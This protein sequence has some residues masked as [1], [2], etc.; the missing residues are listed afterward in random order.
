V[1]TKNGEAY[2][3]AYGNH[4]TVRDVAT[5]KDLLDVEL[6]SMVNQIAFLEGEDGIFVGAACNDGSLPVLSVGAVDDDEST[7]RA[8][9]AIE[10]V[11]GVVAGEERF[12]C[13]QSINYGYHVITANSAGVVSVMNLQGAITMMMS[14]D[15][16]PS[17]N[18]GDANGLDARPNSDDSDDE[19][20]EMELAV[21]I[22]ASVQLGSGARVTCL[23][24]WASP[25][26][27]EEE[28][29]EEDVTDT[30]EPLEQDEGDTRGLKRKEPATTEVEM[31]S[32]A[33]EKARALVNQ[34]KK[35]E[36]KRAKKKRIKAD[37]D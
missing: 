14:E 3:W 29:E 23:A 11:E 17:E 1:W 22:I 9:M 4:I 13:I 26:E 7:R 28:I 37:A 5:G 2:G 35:L 8:L 32:V 20:E 25:L 6:P 24:A 30:E 27:L 33:V 18:D 12:K 15:S 36:K 19:R 16:D 21:D 34:A 31:D 10:P